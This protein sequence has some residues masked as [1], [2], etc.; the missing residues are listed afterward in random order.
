[1]KLGWEAMGSRVMCEGSPYNGPHV[2]HQLTSWSYA[3]TVTSYDM[4]IL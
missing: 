1:M 4:I 3:V 2:T